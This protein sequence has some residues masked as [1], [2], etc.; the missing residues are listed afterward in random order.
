MRQAAALTGRPRTWKI[1]ATHEN[2]RA[3][4]PMRPKHEHT[5]RE[6][7][8]RSPDNLHPKDIPMEENRSASKPM[9]KTEIMAALAEATGLAKPQVASFFDELAVL[10]KKNLAQQGPGEFS[11]PNLMK[12]KVVRKPATPE[13]AG[14]NRFTKEET[15]F[16][17]KPARNDVKIVA[18][19]GL[20]DLVR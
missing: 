10:I 12:I 11:V 7:T 19:K 14:I 1:S 8:D 18:L 4:L 20:K 2:R 3:C 9:N 17:A 5:D 13:R 15:V 16:K 6:L